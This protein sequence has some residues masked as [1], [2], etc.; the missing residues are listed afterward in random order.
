MTRQE[1]SE[2][3]RNAL[4]HSAAGLFDRH[5]Y[6]QACLSE[7]SAGA[8]VSSGALHFHFRNKAALAD[9]VEWSASRCL[10]RAAR[11][12]HHEEGDALQVLTDI[13]HVFA[14]LLREDVVV[15]A[16]VRLNRE[17][18]RVSGMDLHKEWQHCVQ[19][20][21][22][23]AVDEGTF[24][25]EM[26]LSCLASIVVAASTGFEVLGRTNKVWL[27]RSSVTTFWQFML[28]RMAAEH[29]LPAVNPAGRDDAVHF[30]LMAPACG[31]GSPSSL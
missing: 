22:T 13:S 3:T 6:V 5:G 28:P 31:A 14:V 26:P 2:R 1:R 21:L 7:I 12:V 15:R 8:G 30:S 10:H 9:A 27:S 25:P 16:G 29:T 23:R 17:T 11:R 19:R 4:I 18:D 20:L 24:R